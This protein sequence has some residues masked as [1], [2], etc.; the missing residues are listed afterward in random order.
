MRI[1]KFFAASALT[2]LLAACGAGSDSSSQFGSLVSFGDSLSDVGTYGVGTVKQL[3]GGRYTVNGAEG[4]NWIDLMAARLSLP[5]PCAAETGLDGLATQGFSVPA[6]KKPGCTA[7]GQGGARVTNPVGPGNKLLGGGNAVLGQLT[8]PVIT[9]MSNHLAA[10]GGAYKGNEAVFILA[11]GNDVF[12]NLG[13]VGAGAATPTQAVTE[14][15]KAGA[16]LA[17]YIKAFVLG[18]GAQYVTVVN[19]PD[20]SK[21]PF[22]Y[23]LDAN[24]QGLISQM[25]STFNAQLKNG[26]A[27]TNV[28][29]VDAYT[30]GRDQ[31]ANPANYGIS[32][33]TGVAC[34]LDPAVNPLTSSL[35]CS[36]AN[37]IVGDISKYQFADGVH[38]TPFGYS[39]IANAA[40]SEMAKKG[41]IK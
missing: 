19:L 23:S 34:N 13:A 4:K 22:A 1:T 21:T 2:V 28:V 16:E 8:V 37:V 26:L 9:Q 6:T 18:K 31:A 32:N 7:Y 5:A 40:I 14:M 20:V 35:I 36:A 15:G 25:S 39:L 3:G 10:A 33:N 24:T 11:G 12:I 30:V 41:W 17:G 29:Y 27:G 38:P